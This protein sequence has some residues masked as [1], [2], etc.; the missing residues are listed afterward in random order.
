MPSVYNFH[1][2][3]HFIALPS[4]APERALERSTAPPIAIQAKYLARKVDLVPRELTLAAG[5]HR[6]LSWR[7][8]SS[9]MLGPE[10]R[11]ERIQYINANHRHIYIFRGPTTRIISLYAT[12]S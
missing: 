4:K 7:N 9:A 3:L 10:A 2:S 5:V 6:L 11:K 8:Q 1:A 12:V